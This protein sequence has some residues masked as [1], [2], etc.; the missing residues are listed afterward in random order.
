MAIYPRFMRVMRM[1]T[2]IDPVFERR[3]LCKN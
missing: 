3:S 2:V 1:M